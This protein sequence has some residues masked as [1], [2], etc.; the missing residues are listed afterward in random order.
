MQP[1]RPDR[2]QIVCRGAATAVRALLLAFGV[3]ACAAATA[4]ARSDATKVVRYHRYAM[5]VPAAWPVY[6]LTPGSTTCVRFNRHAVY[7][8]TPSTRQRCPASSLGR[9]EAILV[10]PL[11]GGHG[12]Q[13]GGGDQVV[14]PVRA[15][16]VT[17][18][19]TWSHAKSVVQRA[20]RRGDLRPAAEPAAAADF[21]AYARPHASPRA[22][23]T[24]YNGL[25]FDACSA[26]SATQMAAWGASP[27]RAI[28]VYVGGINMACSQPNLNP[29]WVAQQWAAGWHLIPTYV[30]LQAPSNSCGCAAISPT[31]AAAEGTAAAQDAVA[32]AQ[33]VGIGAGNPIYD[34]MESYSRNSTNTPAVLAFLAAWTTQLHTEGYVSGVYGGGLSGMVDLSSQYGTTYAEPDDIWIA[35]WNNQQTTSDPSVPPADWAS[36]QRLHQY[37]GGHNE[38]YNGVTIDIDNDYL[39]GSTA[40]GTVVTPTPALT[41]IP[42]TNGSIRIA[43]SWPGG[44]GLAAWRI[45]GGTQPT[46]LSTLSQNAV[47]GVVT[48]ISE[49]SAYPYYAAEAL[50]ANGNV[51]ATSATVTTGRH[52]AIYGRSIFVP[53]AGLVGVPVGCFTGSA[54]RV[55][56]QMFVGRRRIAHSNAEWLRTSGGLLFIKLSSADRL[57]LARARGHR[58]PVTVVAKDLSGTKASAAMSLIPFTTA[59]PGPRRGVTQAPTLQLIGTSDF[60]YAGSVGGILAG[61]PG[62]APCLIKTQITAGRYTIASTGIEF[63]GANE[64]GYL[65]FKLTPFGRKLLLTTHGNE[66]GARVTLNDGAAI[67][68]A[69]IAL[70]AF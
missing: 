24:L 52:L 14:F 47:G 36:G 19:A 59:G 55:R 18:T 70:S 23:G 37:R 53:S 45:L 41:V 4:G 39:A 12:L 30:G 8:G 60:V 20:L 9:T 7:L 13:L 28:G 50:D 66:L 27:Y 46:A 38:T 2:G 33:A 34:D 31:Q 40:F 32:H 42:N 17:V 5:R 21:R 10:T 44:L 64:A 3:L 56:L 69:T 62:A 51:L 35:D 11:T 29:A 67:A 25:G 57:L 26:P 68:H 65:S 54:C 58:L 15:A 22:T 43:A 48:T 1:Q 6:R 63:I 16:G 49:G 61:C